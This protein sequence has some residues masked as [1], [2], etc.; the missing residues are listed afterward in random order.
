MKDEVL[1]EVSLEEK[2]SFRKKLFGIVDH[3]NRVNANAEKLALRIIETAKTEED[4][5]F[6]RRLIEK[7]RSHD[8]SKFVGIEFESLNKDSDDNIFKLAINQHQ[9]TN[10]H[11]P[12]YWGDIRDMSD[13]ALAE[14]CCDLLSRSQEMGTDLR[15]YIRDV[16]MDRW[17]FNCKTKI[18]HKMK[19]Y[20]DLLLDASFK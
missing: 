11:H 14:F 7:A 8:Q 1:E 12:E 5:T 6:A 18:Y 3:I 9:Q 10:D 20:V 15:L 4:F 16:A 19:H 13:L 17:G 2:D